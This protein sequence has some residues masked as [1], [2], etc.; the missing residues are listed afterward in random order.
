[1]AQRSKI[2]IYNMALLRTGNDKVTE[3]DGSPLW[4]A[5]EAN[6]D[7]I[8]RAAFEGQEFP[9]GKARETLTSRSDGT[10]GYDDAYTLPDAAIH[11]TEVWFDEKYSATT[12]MEPWEL[13]VENKKIL[14]NAEG[15]TIEI[16]YLKAGMEFSWS[17]KFTASIVKSCEAVIKAA[18]EEIEESI[19]R[20]N[21]AEFALMQAGTKAS[22]N[23][24]ATPVRRGGRL[25]RAHRGD[26]A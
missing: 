18:L 13:D 8:V 14:L 3:G 22:R 26:F 2:S 7:E 1:M 9:F 4:Q 10:F 20:E 16:E 12:L 24:S 6:Y 15:R 19:E 5:L 25:I 21:A 23:R 17:S 11:V